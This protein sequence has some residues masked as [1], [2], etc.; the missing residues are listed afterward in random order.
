MSLEE[1]QLF[2]QR[3][4]RLDDKLD[5]IYAAVNQQQATCT[6]ARS[7]LESV[8]LALYGNGRPGLLTRVD[9]LE[10]ER[11]MWMNMLSGALGLVSGVA[12]TVITWLIGK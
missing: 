7:R 9:R 12:G 5:E 4:D 2:Q 3:L 6:A 10:M 8:C 11:R 1:Q